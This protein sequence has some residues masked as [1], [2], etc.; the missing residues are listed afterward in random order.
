MTWLLAPG[1]NVPAKISHGQDVLDRNVQNVPPAKMSV[2]LGDIL[3]WDIFTVN[4]LVGDIIEE[5]L[6]PW[7]DYACTRFLKKGSFRKKDE[8]N[9]IRSVRRIKLLFGRA[10]RARTL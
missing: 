6:G 10:K 2:G 9:V 5:T 4:I 1:H 8:N 3:I 7:I